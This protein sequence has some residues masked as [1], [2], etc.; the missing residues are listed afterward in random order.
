MDT[1]QHQF[2]NVWFF[3]ILKGLKN[4]FALSKEE[5]ARFKVRTNFFEVIVA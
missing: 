4:D 2:V 3:G 5:S 1:H